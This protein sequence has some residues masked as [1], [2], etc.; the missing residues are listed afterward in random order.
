[1]NLFTDIQ[2]FSL[3]CPKLDVSIVSV[4]S[5]RFFPTRID[6]IPSKEIPLKT[7]VWRP[8]GFWLFTFNSLVSLEILLFSTPR[9]TAS[10]LIIKII[11]ITTTTTTA[12][13]ILE[14]NNNTREM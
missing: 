14:I 8:A 3:Q 2:I 4:L 12:A 7:K 10:R 1:M 13:I 5:S 6:R 11:M 9:F